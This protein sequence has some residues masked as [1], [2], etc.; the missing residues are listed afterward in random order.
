[1]VSKN[2]QY[3]VMIILSYVS[4]ISFLKAAW[5]FYRSHFNY[6]QSAG[7]AGS[8]LFGLLTILILLLMAKAVTNPVK[9]NTEENYDY[10]G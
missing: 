5:I 4:C 6:E 3:V 7:A 10:R 1:M 8:A 2:W 9:N